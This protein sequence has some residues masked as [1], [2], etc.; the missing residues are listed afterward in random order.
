[1]AVVPS[2]AA[3]GAIN[4]A[5]EF[6]VDELT[7]EGEDKE[8]KGKR[9]KLLANQRSE[10]SCNEEDSACANLGASPLNYDKIDVIGSAEKVF[11]KNTITS[12]KWVIAT[13]RL[14]VAKRNASEAPKVPD[15]LLENPPEPCVLSKWLS[16][17]ISEVR[18]REGKFYPPKTIWML[19]CGIQR[20]V[21]NI[22][23]SYPGIL[24]GPAQHDF[25]ELHRTREM[26]PK[27]LRTRGKGVRPNPAKLLT[28]EDEKQLWSSGVLDPGNP[29]GLLRAIYFSNEKNLSVRSG[30]SHRQLKLSQF[31]RK[32][33]PNCYIFTKISA[34]SPTANQHITI[35][36]NPVGGGSCHVF[37]LDRYLSKLPSQAFQNDDFYLTPL[38]TTPA[39][40]ITPW[41]STI[42]V[43]RNHLQKMITDMCAEAG[44]P[45]QM[46]NHSL[47]EPGALKSPQTGTRVL[48]CTIN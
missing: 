32:T 48:A 41:Y 26:L 1:M 46:T 35:H 44:I 25:A 19:L 38:S 8:P 4:P 9:R 21:R 33:N 31:K 40:P 22:S 47:N 15:D 45:G 29:L 20:Y 11:S 12:T 43:S 14:W 6:Q 27:Q 3:P 7:E 13:F 24:V 42:P 39:D 10:D 5:P 30:L 18:N 36:A 23:P 2:Q 34:R 37:L 16:A 28:N 17:F